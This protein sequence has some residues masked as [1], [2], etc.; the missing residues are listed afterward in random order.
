MAVMVF[1]RRSRQAR[2]E[3]SERG[4][5]FFEFTLVLPLLLSLVLAI[6]TGGLAYTTKIA[7]TE[8]VREG[9]RFGASLPIPANAGD[10]ASMAAAVVTWKGLV[11]ER[12]VA[13]SGGSLVTTDI[14]VAYLTPVNP[15]T[16]TTTTIPNTN[17]GIS[18]PTSSLSEPSIHLVRVSAKKPARME[19]FLFSK[20]TTLTASAIARYERDI[21]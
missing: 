3:R 18:D 9:A 5:V 17:C 4:A 21:S 7:L 15:S 8:A 2:L 19:F 13:A 6:Y 20:T 10:A 11:S 14:C 12:V 1:H 16:S